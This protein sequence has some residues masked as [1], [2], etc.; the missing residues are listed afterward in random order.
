M[1]TADTSLS[2]LSVP[3]C[4]REAVAARHRPGRRTH[5]L[6]RDHHSSS[7]TPECRGVLPHGQV[8]RPSAYECL[9]ARFRKQGCWVR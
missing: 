3:I 4:H 2:V 1:T 7:L 9:V 6:T 5:T 8:R